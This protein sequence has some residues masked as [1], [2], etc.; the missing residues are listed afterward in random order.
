MAHSH[1][2][3]TVKIR[4][5]CSTQTT[6]RL[7]CLISPRGD[8][9]IVTRY[10]NAARNLVSNN[11]LICFP[12]SRLLLRS[13]ILLCSCPRTHHAARARSS[14]RT[15]WKPACGALHPH[16]FALHPS[17]TSRRTGPKTPLPQ[18]DPGKT[19]IRTGASRGRRRNRRT[20]TRAAGSC[21]RSRPGRTRR[22][23]GRNL[24]GSTRSVFAIRQ[25]HDHRSPLRPRS[26][27]LH[28][29]SSNSIGMHYPGDAFDGD[30]GLLLRYSHHGCKFRTRI[31]FGPR[32]Y[33]QGDT[34]RRRPT[35]ARAFCQRRAGL[36]IPRGGDSLWQLL[37]CRRRILPGHTNHVEALVRHV[38]GVQGP[39]DP[40]PRSV[41]NP[42]PGGRRTQPRQRHRPDERRQE[43][44]GR[45]RADRQGRSAHRSQ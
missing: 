28:T 41:R 8:S 24:L 26:P 9:E 12:P 45:C 17:R 36:Q 23:C 1:A 30:L 2:L 3:R 33:R 22:S 42:L 5:S 35:K 39:E 6:V 44:V 11:V 16:Y 13:Q 40:G 4:S 32:Q 7:F 43:S 37:D 27:S 10:P 14:T 20:G 29:A 19:G 34:S 21:G 15:T 18:P 25:W 31:L 38:P